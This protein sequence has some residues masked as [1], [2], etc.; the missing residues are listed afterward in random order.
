[1][2]ILLII[3][4]LSGLKTYGQDLNINEFLAI[5]EQSML[6]EDGDHS[7][8]IELYNQSD[9]QVDLSGWFLSDDEADRFKWRINE[10]EIEAQ[11]YKLIFASSK[12]RKGPGELHSNFK[13]SS[14]GEALL[15]TNPMGVL[16]DNIE[17][18]ALLEDVSYGSYVDGDKENRT[19]FSPASPGASNDQGSSFSADM[20]LLFLSH[21]A[22]FYDSEFPLEIASSQGLEIRFTLDGSDPLPSSSLFTGS[23][24][25]EDL[26]GN[27][28]VLALVNTGAGWSAPAQTVEKAT[29]VKAASFFQS[30]RR[31]PILTASYFISQ[32]MDQNYAGL[33]VISLSTHYDSL[34]S[35]DRGIYVPGNSYLETDALSTGNFIFRGEEWEREMHLEYFDASHVRVFEQTIGARIHG[36]STRSL[37]QKSLR[38]YAREEYGASHFT[39][40]FF[41]DKDIETFKRV[42]LRSPASDYGNTMFRDELCTELVKDMDMDIMATQM[43]IVFINGTYWGVH[44][45]RE[46]IDEHYIAGNYHLNPDSVNLLSLSGVQEA[47]TAMDFGTLMDFVVSHDLSEQ[48]AFDHVSD[49]IDLNNLI[50]YFIAEVYFA[51]VDWPFVNIRYWKSQEEEARWRWIFHDC[52]RCMLQQEFDHMDNFIEEISLTGNEPEWA[53]TLFHHL[54]NN[55]GFRYEFL[56]RFIFHLSTTFSADRV[57]AKID[58]MEDSYEPLMAEHNNRWNQPGSVLFWKESVDKMRAFVIRRPAVMT[59][60][61]LE[62]FEKPYLLYP[63]PVEQSNGY[64]NLDMKYNE[65]VEARIQFFN[66]MGELVMDVDL[67]AFTIGDDPRLSIERLEAG[68]YFARINYGV[69]YFYDKLVVN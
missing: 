5:N 30:F 65:G 3:A 12:D 64:V 29:V 62:Y 32:R 9:S 13:I 22:G 68:L 1:M 45:I 59:Q 8:W 60:Q 21:E 39:Y 4:F 31:S 49:E 19:L 52:D 42:L 47:G 37:P 10:A 36:K 51:N 25:I 14:S 23:L 57:L 48:E 41:P 27:E 69:L 7:D 50:D 35:A 16:V 38:L 28:D 61:L 2:R 44:T 26:T 66:T 40:P 54:L 56:Q 24:V 18:T 67:N 58:E 11:G 34:F 33:P 43:C 6:D 46:R 20:D 55:D 53:T 63:N 17:A 15:L